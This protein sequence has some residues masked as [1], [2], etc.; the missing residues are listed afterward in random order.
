LVVRSGLA[1][2]PFA[3]DG[4]GFHAD[5]VKVRVDFGLAAATVGGHG[6]GRLAGAF[7]DPVD[8]G[9]ELRSVGRVAFLNRVV[10][11]HSVFIVDDLGFEAELYGFAEAT[12]NDRARVG[13]VQADDPGGRVGLVA[14]KPA[15]RLRDTPSAAVDGRGQFVDGPPQPG[16]GPAGDPAQRSSRVGKHPDGVGA[17][18][19]GDQLDR[20]GKAVQTSADL[21]TVRTS[22][23]SRRG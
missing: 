6:A 21:A 22:A 15:P 12:L 19:E 18:R 1:R 4:N 10:E 14:D 17:A 5:L 13:V 2:L 3:R 9:G 8:G 20:E 11:H 16:L 7:L 23:S